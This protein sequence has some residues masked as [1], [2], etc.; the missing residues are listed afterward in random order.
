ME[1]SSPIMLVRHA[2]FFL[3]FDPRMRY[4]CKSLLKNCAMDFLRLLYTG[5]I[6]TSLIF[7]GFSEFTLSVIHAGLFWGLINAEGK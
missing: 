3:L 1:T 7:T 5:L 2:G 4:L 6:L